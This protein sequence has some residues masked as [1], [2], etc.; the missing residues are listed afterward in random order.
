MPLVLGAV[1]P[2]GSMI[3]PDASD[4][5]GEW[6]EKPASI[7]SMSCQFELV[8]RLIE[9][10]PG[11]EKTG[12]R[13]VEYSLGGDA[14]FHQLLLALKIR[15]RIVQLRLCLL[16]AGTRLLDLS[17]QRQRIDFRKQVP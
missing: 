17:P 8:P 14:S 2:H 15:F 1:A 12:S 9:L 13:L 5:A 7:Q 3:I 6:G 11:R 4:D 10:S 16:H